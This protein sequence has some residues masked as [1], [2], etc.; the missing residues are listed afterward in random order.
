M[1]TTFDLSGFVYVTSGV[2]SQ[3]HTPL[4]SK[5][6]TED[7]SSAATSNVAMAAVKREVI[8]SDPLAYAEINHT[9]T[10]SSESHVHEVNVAA[11]Q[12]SPKEDPLVT[13]FI[14]R[15]R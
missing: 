5:K 3:L 14:K 12:I 2:S 11:P 6:N 8:D 13:D 7:I 9:G 1:V 10:P 4:A 15:S